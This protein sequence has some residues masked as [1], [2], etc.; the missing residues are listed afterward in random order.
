M[1]NNEQF[2]V[3]TARDALSVLTIEMYDNK[4]IPYVLF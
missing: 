4:V 3:K 1:E 2:E